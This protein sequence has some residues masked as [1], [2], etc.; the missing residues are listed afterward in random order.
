M[1]KYKTQISDYLI[2]F[3]CNYQKWKKSYTVVKNEKW[4]IFLYSYAKFI[5]DIQ[6]T[7]RHIPNTYS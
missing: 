1:D 3:T 7:R 5:T 6:V 2:T 4:N